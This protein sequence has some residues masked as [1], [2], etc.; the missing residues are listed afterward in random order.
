MTTDPVI[1]VGKSLN[2]SPEV[3]LTNRVIKV[4]VLLPDA[5]HGYY[6]GPRFDGSGIVRRVEYKDHVYFDRLLRPDMP[7]GDRENHESG[8]IGTA[9]EFGLDIPPPGYDEAKPGD[10]FLKI[11]VGE[12][13]R[14]DSEPYGFWK[15]YP[16]VKPG[17]WQVSRRPITGAAQQI[18]F[19]QKV[20]GPRYWGYDYETVVQLPYP[21]RPEVRI[22]RRLHNNGKKTIRTEHYVHHFMGIDQTPIGPDYRLEFPF[23]SVAT[24]PFDP[25]IVDLRVV[26]SG[27]AATIIRFYKTPQNDIYGELGSIPK[28]AAGNAAVLVNEATGAGIRVSGDRGPSAIHVWG[29]SRVLCPEMFVPVV[30]APGQTM[31]WSIRYIFESGI[32]LPNKKQVSF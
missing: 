12:L 5:N 10:T 29:T 6:R 28:S 14:V 21:D 9:S 19:R 23:A 13:R 11:G 25:K 17:K 30:L 24:R 15:P 22:S 18:S 20:T 27:K 31:N 4:W 1:L 3:V 16:H 2:N 26:S 32:S 7:V 8:A